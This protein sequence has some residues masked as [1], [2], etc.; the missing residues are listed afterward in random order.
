MMVPG[1]EGWSLDLVKLTT[2]ARQSDPIS[3]RMA[4]SQAGWPGF[5]PDGSVSGSVALN[6]GFYPVDGS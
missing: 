6:S 2:R 1:S 4:Q 3:G 5:R